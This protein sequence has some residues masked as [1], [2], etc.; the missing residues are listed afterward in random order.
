MTLRGFGT[1]VLTALLT[2]PAAAGAQEYRTVRQSRRLD[3]SAPVTVT[4]EFAIGRFQ[5][6]PASDGRLYHVDLTYVENLFD[7]SIDYDAARR[8]LDVR[9]SETRGN[10]K[11]RD[12]KN[13]RQALTLQL[14]PNVPLDLDLEFGAV[15]ADLALGGLAL[16]RARVE[17]GASETVLSFDRP[18]AIICDELRL[19]VGAAKLTTRALGN[20]RCRAVRFEGAAG[21]VELDLSGA[22]PEGEVSVDVSV[23]FGEVRLRVPPGIGV[24]LHTERILAR[25]DRADLVKQGSAYYS[26]DYERAATKL[27]IDVSTA[28]GNVVFEWTR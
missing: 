10:I 15:K 16:R 19:E 21:Q 27:D 17:T 7:P 28:V 2:L 12:L 13:P 25:V 26:A 22:W 8:T 1:G 23:A 6:G 20:S 24:R 14:H 5:V 9:V 11:A 4:V 18:N 3:T